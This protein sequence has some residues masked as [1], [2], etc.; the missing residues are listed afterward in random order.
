MVGTAD[1]ADFERQLIGVT[2][3]STF[4]DEMMFIRVVAFVAFSMIALLV[5]GF[6]YITGF[7]NRITRLSALSFGHF[8]L[9]P[10]ALYS[11]LRFGLVVNVTLGLAALQTVADV[12][13]IMLRAIVVDFTALSVVLLVIA[14]IF[15]AL[16]TL[17]VVYLYRLRV[18][19]NRAAEQ[20][21]TFVT[22]FGGLETIDALEREAGVTLDVA[23]LRSLLSTPF[24]NT[25]NEAQLAML[26]AQ[27]RNTLRV[28]ALYSIVAA[29]FVAIFIAI[30]IGSGS[31]STVN[32]SFFQIGHLVLGAYTLFAA[33]R[34]ESLVYYALL[35]L[36]L[37]QTALDITSIVLRATTNSVENDVTVVSL[38]VIINIFL[39]IVA[40]TFLLADGAYVVSA[41]G[42]ITLP[43]RALETAPL[44]VF[45]SSTNSMRV[46]R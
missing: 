2:S 7:E 41:L 3:R 16:D 40:V 9:A 4:S 22:D 13:Q 32:L 33:S 8:L 19:S 26:L 28:A 31:A 44:P 39:F 27:E 6:T 30:F 18:S 1:V 24:S 21:T 15:L 23:A 45:A 20:L 11:T 38:G 34:S 35:V 12:I 5:F 25:L 14:F 46:K 29:L 43:T 36:A 42:V 37:I 10:L 17:Y